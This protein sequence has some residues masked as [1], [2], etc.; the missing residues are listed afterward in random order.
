MNH[1]DHIQKTF[2]LEHLPA[3]I[4]ASQFMGRWPFLRRY[5]R[6]PVGLGWLPAEGRFSYQRAGQLRTIKFNGRNLQFHALYERHYR[7]GY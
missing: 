7:Y 6:L 5:Q 4:R 3:N 2:A 1:F